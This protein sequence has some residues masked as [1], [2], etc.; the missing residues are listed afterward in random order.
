MKRLIILSAAFFISLSL[1][2]AQTKTEKTPKSQTTET[3]AKAGAETKKIKTDTQAQTKI[4]DEDL[5]KY[6]I[7][8]DS[9]DVMQKTLLQVV[10]D[11]VQKNTAMTVQ[12][13]NELNKIAADP[14]KLTAANATAEEIAFVQEI[15]DLKK[16]NLDRINSAFQ[17]LAKDYVG[18]KTFNAIKKSLETDPALKSRFE[19]VSQ[20]LQSEKTS[21]SNK[22]Q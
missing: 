11:N 4:S 13:Y 7:T 6:A 12:R 14:E 1:T 17:S 3:K 15:V 5:K 19:N 18:L 9:V 21:A 2:L 20:E 22:G 16:Y 10:T 8:M